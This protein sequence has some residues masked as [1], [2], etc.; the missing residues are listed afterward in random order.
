MKLSP[1]FLIIGFGMILLGLVSMLLS[2]LY[3]ATWMIV[4]IG[5]LFWI[6][7]VALKFGWVIL[8]NKKVIKFFETKIPN[9]FLGIIT[10]SYLGLLTGIFEVGVLYLLIKDILIIQNS[11]WQGIIG[12][13]AGFGSA[14]SIVLGFVSVVHI[15]YCILKPKA[16]SKEDKKIWEIFNKYK[17]T[18]L[19][20]PI[21]ERIST[22]FIHIFSSVLVILAIQ[23][24]NLIYFFISFF[25]KSLV[26]SIAAWSVLEKKVR[27]WKKTSQI[28][29]VEFILIILGIFSL[30]GLLI[31]LS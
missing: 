21:I 26:D 15:S 4:L 17:F 13:G 22:I 10:W 5:A 19:S 18:T 12:F 29:E 27:N 28:W 3:G 7:T 11:N 9:K 23:Q 16:I 30:L 31:L 8:T 24:A 25:F 6:I 14:E 20:T 1:L 2:H